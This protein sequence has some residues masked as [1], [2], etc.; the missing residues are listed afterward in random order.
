MKQI[1]REQ[2]ID[3]SYLAPRAA[4][5]RISHAKNRMES[6]EAML[7][8]RTN[9]KDEIVAR[10]YDEYTKILRSSG[11]LDFDDLLLKTVELFEKSE[12]VRTA[13]QPALPLRDGG[14]VPG[15]QPAAVPARCAGS[16]STTAT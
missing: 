1:L 3:D 11:A 10:V 14:R 16:P 5:S 9:Y 2:H 15:H 12:V 6:P 8:K 13:L 7:A 4:L